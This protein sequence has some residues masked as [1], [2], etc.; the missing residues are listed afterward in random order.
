VSLGDREA[1]TSTNQRRRER[2]GLIR[3]GRGGGRVRTQECAAGAYDEVL[4]HD[5]TVNR[6]CSTRHAEYDPVQSVVRSYIK[7]IFP[8]VGYSGGH[9]RKSCD[10]PSEHMYLLYCTYNICFKANKVSQV[11]PESGTTGDIGL[12]LQDGWSLK[13]ILVSSGRDCV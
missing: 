4:N 12:L 11:L 5:N 1:I 13:F 10:D 2:L 6:Q 9:L 7:V 8:Q 3:E